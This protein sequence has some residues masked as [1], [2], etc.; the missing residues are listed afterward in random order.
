M[1]SPE[2]LLF[3]YAHFAFLICNNPVINEVLLP[4]DN[5]QT[6][7]PAFD[8]GYAEDFYFGGQVS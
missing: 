3:F 8:Q 4:E 7:T 5:M 1:A 6:L 2:L